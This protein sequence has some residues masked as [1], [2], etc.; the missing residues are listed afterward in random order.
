[1]SVDIKELERIRNLK[2]SR[3]CEHCK[4]GVYI[5]FKFIICANCGKEPLVDKMIKQDIILG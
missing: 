4:V 2:E 3:K 1:M 5:R